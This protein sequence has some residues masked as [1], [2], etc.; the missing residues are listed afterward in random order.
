MES[1]LPV[2]GD[3]FADPN[4]ILICKLQ[5]A[6]PVAFVERYRGE[7]GFEWTTGPWAISGDRDVSCV[8]LRRTWDRIVAGQ[9]FV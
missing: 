7:G 3:D 1:L 9:T 4:K 8:D 6:N 2:V 5:K